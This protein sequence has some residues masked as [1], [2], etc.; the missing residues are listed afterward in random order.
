MQ[1]AQSNALNILRSTPQTLAASQT[2]SSDPQLRMLRRADEALNA[3]QQ[4]KKSSADLAK[5]RAARKL[6]ELQQQVEMLKSGGLSPEATA[7]LAAQLSQKIASAAAQFASA[8]AGAGVTPGAVTAAST[9]TSTAGTAATSSS[10]D[11]ASAEADP[12]TV[13][14]NRACGPGRATRKRQSRVR[15]AT[16][17]ATRPSDTSPPNGRAD[18]PSTHVPDG[19]ARKPPCVRTATR[20]VAA[21]WPRRSQ[22]S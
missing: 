21:S 10:A 2:S 1:I 9:E 20:S 16:G 15:S 6:A 11:A 3:L 22:A 19:A 4:D 18:A 5:E 14:R 7:R 12:A 13:S 8:V 17:D